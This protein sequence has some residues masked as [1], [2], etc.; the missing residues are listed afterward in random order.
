MEYQS[1]V[2]TRICCRLV[3]RLRYCWCCAW[4]EPDLVLWVGFAFRA[5]FKT[6]ENRPIGR[7]IGKLGGDVGTELALG[8]S[9]VVYPGLRM[10][11]Y[12]YFKR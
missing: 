8:F 1:L 3:I 2:A 9:A 12:H 6:N 5:A 10:L 4:N 11:E 7:A